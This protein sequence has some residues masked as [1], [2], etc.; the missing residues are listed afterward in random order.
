LEPGHDPPPQVTL[1]VQTLPPPPP[2]QAALVGC[3]HVPIPSQT[4]SVQGLPSLS[5]AVPGATRLAAQIPA[6]LQ[7]SGASHADAA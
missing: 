5:H 2:P 1:W 7:L 6:A 3:L 4:S